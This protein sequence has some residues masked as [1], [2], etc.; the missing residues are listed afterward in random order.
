MLLTE[1]DDLNIEILMAIAEGSATTRAIQEQ[2]RLTRTPIRQRLKTL[3]G[4]R[5]VVRRK[6]ERGDFFELAAEV[7]VEGLREELRQ[8]KSQTTERKMRRAFLAL[9]EELRVIQGAIG[10]IRQAI[11]EALDE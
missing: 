1:L 9:D 8:R 3:E 7:V 2:V 4:K 10:R 11:A 5:F 6:T